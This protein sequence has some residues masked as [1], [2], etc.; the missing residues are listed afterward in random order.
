MGAMII[1]FLSSNLPIF[2]DSK[3]FGNGMILSLFQQS[4]EW[5]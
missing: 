1:L 2:P 5:K 3:S 4:E